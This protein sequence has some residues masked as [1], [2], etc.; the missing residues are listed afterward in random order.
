MKTVKVLALAIL[1]WLYGLNLWA[2]DFE[3]D[4]LYYNIISLDNLE[5]EATQGDWEDFSPDSVKYSGDYSIP[6]MV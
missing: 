2:Y 5:V 4:G 1:G 6:E 3:V